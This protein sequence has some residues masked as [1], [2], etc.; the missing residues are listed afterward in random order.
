MVNVRESRLIA[1]L[2]DPAVRQRKFARARRGSLQA[3][4]AAGRVLP[5]RPP[6]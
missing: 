6:P 1:G 4:R 3:P 2:G 5:A